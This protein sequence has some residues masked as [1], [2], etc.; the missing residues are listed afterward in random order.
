VKYL[1]ICI[2]NIHDMNKITDF[3]STANKKPRLSEGVTEIT[4]VPESSTSTAGTSEMATT[5]NNDWPSC[6]SLEQ[7]KY[8]CTKY[9]WL[10]VSNQKLGCTCCQ[11]VRTLGVGKKAGIKIHKEWSN[12]EVP[13]NAENGAQQL[14][15]L[16][17]K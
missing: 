7:K 9:E 13:Y 10:H 17:K 16:Q 2:F 1:N 15:S 12:N 6:W 11:K 5:T 3:Y 14:R 4:V 8:F